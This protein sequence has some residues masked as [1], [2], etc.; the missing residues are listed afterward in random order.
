MRTDRH[1]GEERHAELRSVHVV[2]AEQSKHRRVLQHAGGLAGAS[3][4]GRFF[5]GD[6]KRRVVRT[7]QQIELLLDVVVAPQPF[8]PIAGARTGKRREELVEC[9]DGRGE[10][11]TLRSEKMSERAG[12]R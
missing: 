1:G 11:R 7:K 4:N 10:L 5:N 3:L 8:L 9:L 12:K 2:I 6:G